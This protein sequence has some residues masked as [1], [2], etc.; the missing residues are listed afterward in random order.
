MPTLTI[1]FYRIRGVWVLTT[2]GISII[3]AWM[4]GGFAPEGVTIVHAPSLVE[5]PV[6]LATG[7]GHQTDNLF[8]GKELYHSGRIRSM[9]T[10]SAVK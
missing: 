4:S 6:P 7:I 8:P 5:M 9:C 3:V 1:E 10:I 2:R